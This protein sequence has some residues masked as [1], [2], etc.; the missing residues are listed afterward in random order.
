MVSVLVPTYQHADFI[1]VCL[2]GILMQQCDFPVEILVGEDESSD[3]TREICQR[4]AALY[5]DRIRLFLRSRKDVIYINGVPTGRAN[6][7][8][9][10]RE[11]NGKY[12]ALCEGDDVWI[13]PS[14][15]AKQV[16]LLESDQS[17]SGVYHATRIIDEN[18]IDSGKLMRNALPSQFTLAGT[19][20]PLSPFHT[21]SFVFRA[22]P[23]RIGVPAWALKMPSLDM[24]LFVLVAGEGVLRRVDGVM[25]SYRKH[26]GGITTTAMHHGSFFH[27]QRILI[28]LNV[29]RH[30]DYRQTDRSKELF[31][32]HWNRVLLISDR[33]QRLRYWLRLVF[34]VP[35]W[36]LR[37]PRFA[38]GRLREA[39]R[40]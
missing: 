40:A 15:L 10:M 22:E 14:K 38:L 24:V 17:I 6:L 26:E 37:N 7:L 20:A 13:D 5:P 34:N 19:M 8:G 32:H 21:S 33:R 39:L 28:W 11:A 30:F 18:G 9:L 12:L 16:A 4:Y 2:D 27:F 29:D 35:I 23:Y 3:G 36:F 25:S 31:S 1:A